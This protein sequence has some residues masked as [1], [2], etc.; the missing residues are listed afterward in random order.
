MEDRSFSHRHL[1]QLAQRK[2]SYISNVTL[3]DRL[4]VGVDNLSAQEA[5]SYLEQRK[6]FDRVLRQPANEIQKLASLCK[7]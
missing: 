6:V 7:A 1:Q 4:G 2:G 3:P 5:R